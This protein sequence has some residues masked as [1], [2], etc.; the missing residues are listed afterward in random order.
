[1]PISEK[2]AEL[3]KQMKEL[4]GFVGFNYDLRKPIT[5]GAARKIREYHEELQRLTARPNRVYR[6]R[7]SKRLKAAQQFA[8]H[9]GG[10]KD[11]KVAFVPAVAGTKLK[12]TKSGGV[13][14][15]TDNIRAVQIPL[16]PIKVARD[17]E[18][19]ARRAIAKEPKAKRFQI[20]TNE[21]LIPQSYSASKLPEAITRLVT[22]YSPGGDKYVERKHGGTVTSS[23]NVN[24]WLNGV[25]AYYFDNQATV[26]DFGKVQAKREKAKAEL[27]KKRRNKKRRK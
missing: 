24:Q 19:E 13:Y 4:R 20:M 9:P 11:F 18:G 25:T 12:F 7:N 22:R 27:K 14:T 5:G 15:R 16:D 23:N 2:Q 21:F 1:M 8:Q 17:P 26:E 6:A 10:F 3:R